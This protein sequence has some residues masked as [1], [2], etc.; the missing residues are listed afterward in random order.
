MTTSSQASVQER[1]LSIDALRGFDMFWIIGAI[2]TE[3]RPFADDLA[4]GRG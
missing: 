2:P 4:R 3:C 1:L